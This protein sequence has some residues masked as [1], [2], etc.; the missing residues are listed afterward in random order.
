MGLFVFS[1]AAHNRS[2]A[3]CEWAIYERPACMFHGKSA[4]DGNAFWW[5]LE[6]LLLLM[7]LFVLL[8]LLLALLVWLSRARITSDACEHAGRGPGSGVYVKVSPVA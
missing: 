5:T 8:W 7:L 4:N 2:S 3:S 6:L 1:S